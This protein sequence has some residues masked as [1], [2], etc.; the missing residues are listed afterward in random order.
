MLLW[1]IYLQIFEANS[2]LIIFKQ[3]YL[4]LLR[5]L[6]SYSKLNLRQNK[7][8]SFLSRDE[9]N[10]IHSTNY[11]GCMSSV[12]KLSPGQSLI[13]I[14]LSCLAVFFSFLSIANRALL[15]DQPQQKERA[16]GIQK[17]YTK[18]LKES[19]KVLLVKYTKGKQTT[20][21]TIMLFD[22]HLWM[23]EWMNEYSY[24]Q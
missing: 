7:T 17:R 4:D 2:Y 8:N 16:L 18:S 11:T 20:R 24:K 3:K 19:E 10:R 6:T 1:A 15:L 14:L 13:Y 9:R 22:Y 12:S 5:Y 21:K 23:N